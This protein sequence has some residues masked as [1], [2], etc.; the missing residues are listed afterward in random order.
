MVVFPVI[1]A[2]LAVGAS[3]R[4][5]FDKR[6]RVKWRL[7]R[8]KQVPI[9]ELA[10]GQRARIGGTARALGETLEA[11]LTGRPC[12]AF[13]VRVE[14]RRT[15]LPTGFAPTD[16]KIWRLLAIEQGGVPFAIEDSSGRALVDPAHADIVLELDAAQEVGE[17]SARATAFCARHGIVI[18][19]KHLRYR[20]GVIAIG[21][22]VA[23][24][25]EGVREPDRKAAPASYRGDQP[26]VM[27]LSSSAKRPLAIANGPRA[28]K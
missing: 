20:E 9:G 15:Y 13:D 8:A 14:E 4:W 6:R 1:A 11:P 27:R 26:T 2:A 3:A 25:G 28:A 22:S 23:V 7:G 5:T 12:V 10:E 21:E 24:L 16:S 18:A 17:T 19:R